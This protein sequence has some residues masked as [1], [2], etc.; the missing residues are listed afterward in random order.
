MGIISS[1]QLNEAAFC[2]LGFAGIELKLE[3]PYDNLGNSDKALYGHYTEY[4]R[5]IQ[6]DLLHSKGIRNLDKALNGFR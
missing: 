3:G 6:L 2:R 1:H 5:R 4:E